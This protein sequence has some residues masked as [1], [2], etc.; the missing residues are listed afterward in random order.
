MGLTIKYAIKGEGTDLLHHTVDIWKA[1]PEAE[2]YR[3]AIT[4]S[5][6]P[7][8]HPGSVAYPTEPEYFS[9]TGTGYYNLEQEEA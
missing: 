1:V 2:F 3:L 8:R 6:N 9:T 7:N 4:A 5:P